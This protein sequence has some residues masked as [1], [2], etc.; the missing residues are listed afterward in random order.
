MAI[1]IDVYV[2]IIGLLAWST[3][4]IAWA[5]WKNRQ[6]GERTTEEEATGLTETEM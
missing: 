5:V 3:A 6:E 2:T 1:G 4:T